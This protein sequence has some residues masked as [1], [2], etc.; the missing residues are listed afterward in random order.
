MLELDAITAGYERGAPVVRDAQ[1]TVEP[2]EAVGL[3]GPSGCGKSTLARVAALLHR[4]DAGTV[5]LDGRTVTGWRH[6]APR[7]Q[8]TAVGVVFQ[9]PRMSADPRLRLRDLIAEP[10]RA[11]GRRNEAAERVGELAATVGLGDELLGRRP[12][13]VSDGQLQRACLARA[14]VLRPRW[15]VCDE[16]TAMLDASTTAALIAVVEAYRRERGAGLLAV[17]HDRV[18]LERWCDRTLRWEDVA[19]A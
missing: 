10:L 1:L 3:L 15:L 11:T 16:M 18:L 12:H 14:L 17:G 4:P 8:R 5:T 7:E 6:R 13:E 19:A 2:G 9:Q